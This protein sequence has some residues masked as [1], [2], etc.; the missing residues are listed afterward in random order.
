[1]ERTQTPTMDGKIDSELKFNR[2]VSAMQARDD[3]EGMKRKHC[4]QLTVNQLKDELRK[5]NL[6]I[7]G[8][9]N[10][11]IDRLI[12]VYEIPKLKI[13]R[14]NNRLKNR[15]N[16]DKANDNLFSMSDE[17]FKNEVIN[18]FKHRLQS[19]AS[20]QE[21]HLEVHFS[22]I[23]TAHIE[24]AN[25][26]QNVCDEITAGKKIDSTERYKQI[27]DII[28]EIVKAGRNALGPAISW[29]II[30][31]DNNLG[32]VVLPQGAEFILAR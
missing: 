13:K 4:E 31:M 10:D 23:E 5:K 26:R 25:W 12:P 8:K 2:H 19:V 30:T 29:S 32:F 15:Y 21:S 7:S 18:H 9:K 1:M 24:Y 3:F 27:D 11:L 17:K 22:A 6:K 16:T 20:G 14:V 28:M